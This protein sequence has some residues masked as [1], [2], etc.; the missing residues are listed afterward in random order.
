MTKQEREHSRVL[1]EELG[2]PR[3]GP[4]HRGRELGLD[5]HRVG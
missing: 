1:G 5:S 4:S 3:P 2:S